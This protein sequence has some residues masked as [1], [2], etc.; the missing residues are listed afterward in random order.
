MFPLKDILMR[1]ANFPVCISLRNTLGIRPKFYK[2]PALNCSVSDLFFWKSDK[3]WQTCFELL[4]VPSVLYPK[5][6][7]SDNISLI[8]YDQQGQEFHREKFTIPPFQ[9]RTIQVDDI[10][11]DN[12]GCG[13][14]ACFHEN[15]EYLKSIQPETCIV[16]RGFVAYRRVTDA[17]PLWSYIHGAAYLLAKSPGQNK[18][19]STRRILGKNYLYRPQLSFSDCD[20]FDLIYINPNDSNLAV[21]IRALDQNSKIIREESEVLCPRG[22][23]I[24]S[25]NNSDR[26]IS[27]VENE[28]RAYMWRPFILKYYKTHF[29]ILHG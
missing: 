5:K 7:I 11:G 26:A 6:N 1:L 23:K 28:G 14:V 15:L 29:D 13:T 20:R 18:V 12:A 27:L 21:K 2:E 8:F 24:F 3:T 19:Q 9:K 25:L 22:V 16:E 17:S 10:I 4:N